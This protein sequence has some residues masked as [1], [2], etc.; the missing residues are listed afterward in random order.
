MKVAQKEI[1]DTCKL[2]INN[3]ID[4]IEGCRKIL[5]LRNQFQLGNNPYL[6]PFIGVVSEFENYPHECIRENFSSNYLS[7]ADEE[8]TNYITEIK[9]SIIEACHKLITYYEK[10]DT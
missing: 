5:S 8:I 1:T 3:E 2:L 9:E 7:K 6:L 10:F 4:F